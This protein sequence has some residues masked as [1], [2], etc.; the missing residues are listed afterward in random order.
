M[1]WLMTELDSFVVHEFL[2]TFCCFVY[3]KNRAARSSL[4]VFLAFGVGF[5]IR[6]SPAI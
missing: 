3:E 6:P 1:V 2:F 5:A 4:L